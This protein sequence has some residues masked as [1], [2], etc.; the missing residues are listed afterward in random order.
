MN[1]WPLFAPDVIG[2]S[3]KGCLIHLYIL[4][5]FWFI[6]SEIRY[7][8]IIFVLDGNKSFLIVNKC[9]CVAISLLLDFDDHHVHTYLWQQLCCFCMILPLDINNFWYIKLI[10]WTS[11]LNS[12]YRFQFQFKQG[13][14]FADFSFS[15]GKIFAFAD[16]SFSLG[17]VLHLLFVVSCRAVSIVFY[18]VDE[19]YY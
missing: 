11:I 7:F 14:C 6:C 17:K 9:Y 16:F 3:G 5:F 15:L 2:P 12:L 18:V 13:I 1:H 10:S 8:I 19:V 4:F